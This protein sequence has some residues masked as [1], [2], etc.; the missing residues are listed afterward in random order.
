M[1]EPQSVIAQVIVERD[2]LLRYLD[3]TPR[4]TGA[5]DDW[6]AAFAPEELEGLNARLAMGSYRYHVRRILSASASTGRFCRYA[7]SSRTFTFGTFF[8]SQDVED[9]A[10]FF[11]VAR[12]IAT[13]LRAGRTG[14]ASISKTLWSDETFALLEISSNRSKFL[15]TR[16]GLYALRR[17]DAERELSGLKLA[18]AVENPVPIDH[19]DAV[20]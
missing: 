15:E 5:W 3:A 8:Y 1:S 18:Y 19:L 2:D 4:Q 17:R 13:F 9:F 6:H 14:F 12:G 20:R 11:A 10:Y 7:E 16:D